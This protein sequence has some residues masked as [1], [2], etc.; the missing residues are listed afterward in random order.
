MRY[1]VAALAGAVAIWIA[2][3]KPADL[4]A[5]QAYSAALIVVTLALWATA[6]VPEILTSLLFFLFAMLIALAPADVVFSGFHSTANWIVFGGLVIGAA[7]Q[8]AG[9]GERIA[10]AL[11]KRFSFGYAGIIAGMVTIGV[12]LALLMPSGMGRIVLLAP[13]AMALAARFG[14]EPGSNGY[15]G[16]VL[17][18]GYGTS[19]PAAGILPANVPNLVLLGGAETVYDVVLTYGPYLLLHFPVL[20][21]L[22]AVMLVGVVVV[23]FPDRP[24]FL[25]HQ[26]VAASPSAAEKRLG[27]FL[28]FALLAWMTDFVHQVSPA[29][30]ALAAA[31]AC[32][33]PIIGVLPRTIFAGGINF[34]PIFFT[35]AILGVGALVAHVGL[36]DLVGRELR[37]TIEFEPG[38]NLATFS[39]VVG[40]DMILGGLV[41]TPGIPAVMVPLSGSIAEAAGLPVETVLMMHAVGYSTYFLPYQMAPVMIAAAICNVSIAVLTR[42]CVVMGVLSLI[43][44]LPINYLWWLVLGYVS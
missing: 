29:W 41:T 4:N 8:T 21:L 3:A 23:L 18:M 10:N 5:N 22:K 43:V 24:K 11:V 9:L 20:G 26:Q 44:L 37:E 42:L 34:V 16:V 31:L 35:A 30:V 32:L 39:A 12:V 38:D 27:L 14:F 2:L 25:E 19:A 36:G 13:I 6:I 1:I 15:L 28:A 40:I 17:A 33:L 7:V